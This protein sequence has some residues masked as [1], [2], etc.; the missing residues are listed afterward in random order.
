MAVITI[1]RQ[2]GSGG[3]D[4]AARACELLG[5]RYLDKLLMTQAA[6]EVGLSG[7]ELA[8]FSERQPKVRRF[9]ERLVLPGPRDLARISVRSRDV[10]GVETLTV[11]HLD[12]AR[13]SSLV[14]GA[15]HAA[16]QEGEVV[17]VGRGGQATLRDLPGV[18]HVRIEA[19]IGT[20]ILRV[21]RRK[22]LD[23]EQARRLVIQHDQAAAQYLK[24][25]FGIAW[26]DPMLY[27]AVINT[28]RWETETAAQIIVY[29]AGQ[30]PT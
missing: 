19:P 17:I 3:R 15:I 18:L 14:Q 8:E 30:L 4:I 2:S 20:R 25:L 23:A 24:R 11:K 9:L 29:L 26:E 22:G 21:Q 10:S 7:R 6:A 13:S 27:H 28:G 16:Y 1:S 5:Y 12:E